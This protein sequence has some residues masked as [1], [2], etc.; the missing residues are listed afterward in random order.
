M[1]LKMKVQIVIAKINRISPLP[2]FPKK[3]HAVGC[4]SSPFLVFQK[5]GSVS[6]FALAGVLKK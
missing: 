3:H 5:E 4:V 1:F 6:V 2:V